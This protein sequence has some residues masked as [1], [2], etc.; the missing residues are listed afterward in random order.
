MLD[1]LLTPLSGSP[2]HSVEPWAF[3]HARA[4]VLGWGV[5]IPLGGLIAR[6]LKVTPGQDW[7]RALDNKTWWH[8]HRACQYGG[9]AIAALGVMIAWG[10][11]DGRAD[12]AWL[13]ALVGWAVM[14]AG[15]AQIV[16]GW[17]R[18]S[19]GG[20]TEPMLRG[21]HFD[22]TRRRLWFER[23]HKSLG[24]VAIACGLATIALGLVVADA[25]RWMAAALAIWWLGLACWAVAMQRAGRCLDTYQ[26]IWGPDP[27]LPGNRIAPIGWGV[28]R[29]SPQ[30]RGAAPI[31]PAEGRT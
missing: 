2:D 1:W 20:P 30:A 19:K 16:G 22:M 11:G 5:L 26:A 28:R 21:D 10:R 15:L 29:A 8:M 4:M 25:P 24:W 23:I 31:G 9:V 7:P 13:H 3:W 27:A 17:L 18:G 14:A 12:G 6:Y